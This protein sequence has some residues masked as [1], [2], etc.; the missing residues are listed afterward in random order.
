MWYLGDLA[1]S[2]HLAQV[3]R[4]VARRPRR[5]AV[6]RLQSPRVLRPAVVR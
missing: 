3:A 2:L 5:G 4:P 6:G 1:W